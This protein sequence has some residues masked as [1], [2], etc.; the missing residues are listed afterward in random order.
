MLIRA[1]M[2]K[3][4]PNFFV[5]IMAGRFLWI[6]INWLSCLELEERLPMFFWLLRVLEQLGLIL[7]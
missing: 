4:V 6:L 5:I 1:G 3:N 2:L 7:M